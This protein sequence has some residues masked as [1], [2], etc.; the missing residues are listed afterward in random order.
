MR[1]RFAQHLA[2]TGLIPEGARVLLGYSGG[3]DSTCL[4]HLLAELGVDVVAAHLHHGMRPEA[5]REQKLCEA[6]AESLGIPFATGRADVPRLAA[7]RKIGLE[8]AGREARYGFFRQAAS[9]LDC[10]LIATAHTRDDQ[11]ETVLFRIAR[12]TGLAGLAGIPQ[13]REGIVRPLLSFSRAETR[14]FCEERGLWFHDDPANEDRANARVRVRLDVV[15]ALRKINPAAD[16]AIVRLAAMA[17]EEDRFLDGAAAAALER[18]E[19][20]L[21]GELAFLTQDVELAFDR[22]TL[23][24]LP[25]VLLRRAVRLAAGALGAE[26]DFDGAASV[27]QGEKGSLTAEG[28]QV[29]L[30]WNAETLHGRVLSPTVPFRYPLTLPGETESEEFGWRLVAYPVEASPEPPKRAALAVE[31]DRSVT[32]GGLHFRGFAPGDTMRP[33]GFDGTRKLSDLLGEA[34]LTAAAR[35]R[36]PIVCDMVGPVWAPGVCLDERARPKGGA[37]VALRLEGLGT[38]D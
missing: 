8:E 10:T 17:E 36:L 13:S 7:D 30:E 19:V 25:A 29:V 31:I 15:P 37:A 20:R 27:L 1:E 26:L 35:A 18:A 33:L 14:A 5:D 32:R 23:E 34:G 4:L 12:G 2:E 24:H 28:G 22:R 9:R 38:K 16:E 6:T 21:N 11:V 3:A